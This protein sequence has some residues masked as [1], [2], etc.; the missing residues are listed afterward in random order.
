MEKM[1]AGTS[2]KMACSKYRVKSWLR[3]PG[4]AKGPNVAS[5]DEQ[6]EAIVSFSNRKTASVQRAWFLSNSTPVQGADGFYCRLLVQAS[7]L[8][9]AFGER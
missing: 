2:A 4:S 6:L 3:Q 8:G 1:A 5:A 9:S 7:K